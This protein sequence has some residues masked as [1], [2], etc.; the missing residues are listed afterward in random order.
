MA[1]LMEGLFKLQVLVELADRLSGPMGRIVSGLG[2]ME[3]M[4]DRADEA[5]NRLQAGASI[6]AVGLALAAPLAGATAQA[7]A[8]EAAFSDVRKVVDFPTPQGPA[9]LQKQ[10]RDLSREIP[11]T[12][13][14]LTE[15]AAAGGQAGI[16]LQDLAKFIENT[17]KVSTAL[18]INA[19]QAGDTIAQL[20]V[21]FKGTQPEVLLMADAVNA[22]SNTTAAK[23]P[24]ILE[25]LRRVGSVGAPL[26]M[27]AQQ[28]SAFSA[29]LLSTGRAPEVVSSG[30]NALINRLSM[31]T[32][33]AKPFQKGL[34]AI[35]YTA[36]GMEALVRK[37]A[38]GAVLGFLDTLK[39]APNARTAIGQMFGMEYADDV[40]ALMNVLPEVK[41]NLGLVGQQTNYAGSIQAEYAKRL[42]T[43]D[44]RLKIFRNSLQNLGITIGNYVLPPFTK[45]LDAGT[46]FVKWLDSA[47]QA[48]PA[49]TQTVLAVVAGLALL[50]V[51]AGGLVAALGVLGFAGAQARIG[52][53]VLRDAASAAALGLYDA[54][55]RADAFAAR[56]AAAGGVL[57]FLRGQLLAAT[58]AA[59]AFTA[60]LLANPVVMIAA[61]VIGLGAA[62]VW[63]WNNVDAFR[64]NVL[65]ALLPLRTAWFEFMAAISQLGAALGP[66]GAWF[67]S[68]IPAAMGPLEAIA[69]GFGF[70][71]GA[72]L[73]LGTKVF[74]R[75]GAA[76]LQGLTGVVNVVRGFVNVV[77]GLFRGDLD[78]ARRGAQQVWTGIQQILSVPLRLLAPN[79]EALRG[80][81]HAAWEWVKNFAH[82]MYLAGVN[83]VQ[84][85]INGIASKVGGVVEA[86]KRVTGLANTTVT[87]ETDQR[88]PSRLWRHYGAMLPA[89][90][91]LGVLGGAPAL[92]RAVEALPLT[93]PARAAALPGSPAPFPA[94]P[95]AP[96]PA[97]PARPPAVATA[98]PRFFAP[99]E[100]T[101]SA[102]LEP[103]APPALSVVPDLRGFALGA[104][105]PPA[106]PALEAPALPALPA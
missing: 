42:E 2:G 98:A 19:G 73:T 6:A 33:Q 83:L 1:T 3:Q 88:S 82:N 36:E 90:L 61:A 76:V 65:A 63:A 93:P 84:G 58:G 57:P 35:G 97:A 34:A 92:A 103:F 47:A 24:D 29:A 94:A 21:I 38:T 104:T 62:F 64:V 75:L 48:N 22:L 23:A 105:R 37:D 44:A 89:G 67:Q 14:Q 100:Q 8:F 60:A 54:A 79:W 45:V 77:V 5:L 43:A 41:T 87:T 32:I 101:V 11:L 106:R 46:R 80:A 53:A 10:I 74:A 68:L 99:L 25:T 96:R 12:V 28:I 52:L 9:I 86:V 30:L 55:G 26:G 18:D 39:Q 70:M 49:L 66:V 7:V 27:T 85:L 20:A 81:L 56:V 91:A 4:A 102:R 72:L 15:I 78:L 50:A 40:L 59:R 13:T 16:P 51:G 17:A 95:A 69:Y 31:A 71:V